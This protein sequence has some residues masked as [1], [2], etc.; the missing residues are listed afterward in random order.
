M[1]SCHSPVHAALPHGQAIPSS[2]PSTGLSEH[3]EP[4][5]PLQTGMLPVGGRKSAPC[6]MHAYLLRQHAFALLHAAGGWWVH[7]HGAHGPGAAPASGY[8]PR[9]RTKHR[10]QWLGSPL[11]LQGNNTSLHVLAP[12]VVQPG[13][14]LAALEAAAHASAQGQQQQ[15]ARKRAPRR[16]ESLKS[17]LKLESYDF[18]PDVDVANAQVGCNA[19]HGVCLDWVAVASAVHGGL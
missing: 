14:E 19:W 17:L 5:S 8:G 16:H 13:D 10:L 15:P 12:L 1:R 7:C 2:I 4:H 18:V 6:S 3:G 9:G 11:A